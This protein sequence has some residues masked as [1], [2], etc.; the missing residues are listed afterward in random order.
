M[1]NTF[2]KKGATVLIGLL[3]LFKSVLIVFS[4]SLVIIS[5]DQVPILN[6]RHQ[7]EEWTG[8]LSTLPELGTVE[9][10][11]G[12]VIKADHEATWYKFGDRKILFTCK[13]SLKAGIDLSKLTNED[14]KTNFKQKSISITLPKAEL[15]TLNI[16]PEEIF[17]VYEKRTLFRSSFTNDERNS[18][19]VQ[20]E[21]SIRENVSELGILDDAEINAK[22]FMESFLRRAGYKI[23]NISFKDK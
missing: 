5:C 17:L 14:I 9:Y 3:V 7:L 4:V 23:I 20:G 8:K 1:S 13:A 10:V 19:L 21:K 2:C 16:K 12:K 6:T 22:I 15:M 18:I 11:I